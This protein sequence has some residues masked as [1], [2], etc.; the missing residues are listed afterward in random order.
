MDKLFEFDGNRNIVPTPEI[1]IFPCFKKLWTRD[2][3]K[4]KEIAVGE[5]GYIWY[6]CTQN[7]TRNPYYEKYAN[8]EVD[9]SKAIIK[10]LF[11]KE[12]Q[13]DTLVKECMELFIN[14]TYTEFKDTRDALITAKTKLK[15]W[16]KTYDP[17]I[18]D[19]GMLI[20]RNTKSISEL[21]K[22][23]KEYNELVIQ[24]EADY[25][26]IRGGGELGAFEEE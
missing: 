21:T 11:N 2:K 4:G 24:E 18:D 14:N 8:N 6:M 16:F 17:S 26:N 10:D 12:W 7:L 3:S 20:Q 15:T 9:K 23:I 1:L 5:L 22:V 19:D 25:D 13:P